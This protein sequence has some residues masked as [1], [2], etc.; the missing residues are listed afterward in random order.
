MAAAKASGTFGGTGNGNVANVD[1][2]PIALDIFGVFVGTVVLERSV[3]A[4][5]NWIPVNYNYSATPISFTA[6]ASAMIENVETCQYRWRCSAHTSGTI[7]YR[8]GQ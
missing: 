1:R 3:D 6:P 8:I 4:G 2:G 7:S 5:A